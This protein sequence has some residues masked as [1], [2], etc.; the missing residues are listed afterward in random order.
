M[1]VYVS[2]PRRACLQLLKAAAA[3]LCRLFES[4]GAY[5]HCYGFTLA[6]SACRGGLIGCTQARRGG[7][8]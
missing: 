1:M 2:P 5:E 4:A 6:T 3:G 8:V 7:L